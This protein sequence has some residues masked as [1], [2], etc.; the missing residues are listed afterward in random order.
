MCIDAG[1]LRVDGNAIPFR[2][3]DEHRVAAL[4][5]EQGRTFAK[6]FTQG[7]AVSWWSKKMDAIGV[8]PGYVIT[9]I[10]PG[11]FGEVFGCTNDPKRRECVAETLATYRI[12]GVPI[13]SW[14]ASVDLDPPPFPEKSR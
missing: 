1:L 12:A 13:W 9:D 5:V 11:V 4:L 6:P 2:S 10:F 3:S 7:N 8:T 14:D